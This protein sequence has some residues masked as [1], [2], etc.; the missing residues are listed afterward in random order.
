MA[1]TSAMISWRCLTFAELSKDELYDALALRNE[2]FVGEQRIVFADTDYKDQEAWHVLGYDNEGKC[3]A[4]CR[5]FAPG[6]V[7]NGAAVGRVCNSSKVRGKGVGKALMRRAQEE[8]YRLFGP[9]TVIE[10]SA[11]AYLRKFYGDLGFEH[12]GKPEYVDAGI[13]HIHMHMHH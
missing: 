3:V 4:Y 10:L 2:V 1:D 6:V 12:D 11:Q 8:I 7:Y 9:T 13:L 5:F